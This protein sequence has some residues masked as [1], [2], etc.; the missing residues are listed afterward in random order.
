MDSSGTAVG[1][2]RGLNPQL[3]SQANTKQVMLLC[4]VLITTAVVVAPVGW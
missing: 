4:V 2:S 3:A 1:P